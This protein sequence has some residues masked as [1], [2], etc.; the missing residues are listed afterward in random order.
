MRTG[1]PGVVCSEGD[2]VVLD[3]ELYEEGAV[4]V[5]AARGLEEAGLSDAAGG[6]WGEGETGDGPLFVEHVG[7]EVGEKGVERA[8]RCSEGVDIAHGM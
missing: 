7:G 5:A 1:E 4:A 8:G 6:E 2:G 3:K